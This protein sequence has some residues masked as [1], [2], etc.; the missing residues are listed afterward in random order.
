MASL[1]K[2]E[3]ALPYLKE[4]LSIYDTLYENNPQNQPFI[5]PRLMVL[6]ALG[7]AYFLHKQ[8]QRALEKQVLA[9]QGAKDAAALLGDPEGLLK[10]SMLY[11]L[12]LALAHFAVDDLAGAEADLAEC[13]IMLDSALSAPE[14]IIGILAIKAQLIGSAYLEKHKP[15]K[16]RRY[17]LQS[18]GIYEALPHPTP[19]NW[20]G[21]I[22]AL[23]GVVASDTEIFNKTREKEAR[24]EA[25]IYLTMAKVLYEKLPEDLPNRIG[26]LEQIKYAEDRLKKASKS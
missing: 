11:Q 5:N 6:N 2:S 19:F 3:E 9:V 22:N 1:G 10:M 14:S 25:K 23:L 7:N 13:Q 18:L 21:E 26:L 17:F 20:I 4:S 15:Q 16:A 12:D 24:R 8:P